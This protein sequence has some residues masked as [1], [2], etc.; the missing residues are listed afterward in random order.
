[1][2]TRTPMMVVLLLLSGCALTS[3][4]DPMEVRYFTPE[5][6]VGGTRAQTAVPVSAEGLGLALGRI[7]ASAY[8]R[9]RIAFRASA[10]ELGF[11][12]TQ[13]WT[14]R[15]ES[16]LRRALATS[17]FEQRGL[18]PNLGGP[19]ATL[20]VEL[21]AFEETRMPTRVARLQIV[22]VLYGAGAPSIVRTVTVERTI[23]RS[24]DPTLDVVRALSAALDEGVARISDEVIARLRADASQVQDAAQA[25]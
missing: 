7:R 1:M 8:L 9:E 4:S 14:E 18:E 2:N 13:R 15:P 12:E 19:G 11:Y 23:E 20:D 22:Y 21:V 17:L 6:S 10:N 5:S 25:Q 24:A 3:K 16:Y